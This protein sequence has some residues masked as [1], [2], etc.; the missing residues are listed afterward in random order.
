M[1]QTKVSLSD[2]DVDFLTG[3][4]ELGYPDKSSLVRAALER[5]RKELAQERLRQ[6]A[7]LYAD[8]YAA[9]ADLQE[10]TDQAIEEWPT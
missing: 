3:F 6:S 4:Q 5:F 8:I 7:D 2:E 10:L 9:D 1:P